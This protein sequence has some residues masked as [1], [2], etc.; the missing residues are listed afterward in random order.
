MTDRT[1]FGKCVGGSE[2]MGCPTQDWLP[3]DP[4][5]SGL[6]WTVLADGRVCCPLCSRSRRNAHQESR[7]VRAEEALEKISGIVESPP[8]WQFW[9]RR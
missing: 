8:W 3:R 1:Y 5:T 9:R 2:V 4:S 7:L 6:G